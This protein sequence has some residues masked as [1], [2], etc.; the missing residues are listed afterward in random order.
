MLSAAITVILALLYYLWREGYIPRDPTGNGIVVG[1]AKAFDNRALSLR[2]ERL[3]A[4]LEALKVVNQSVTD[5][6][7]N[8]QGQTSTESAQA[9]SVAAKIA[10]AGGDGDGDGKNK[11]DADNRS[12]GGFDATRPEFKPTFGLA[13][14]DVLNNQLNL[15]SQIVNLQ[16]LYERSLSDRMIGNQSKLQT[17]LG[18]QISITPPAGYEDCVA[19]TEVA[20]RM[21]NKDGPV[22]LV[23]LMPQEKTYNAET[24]SS[25]ERSI[26]GS[27]V[28]PALTIG[29][30]GKGKA[31]QLFVHRDS[32]TIAFERSPQVTPTLFPDNGDHIV[33]GWEFR[34]VLGRRTVSPG[35]RQ[36]LAVV[37]LPKPDHEPPEK[38]ALEIRTRSYWRYYDRK[39]QVSAPHAGWL[40]W[41]IDGAGTFTSE[42]QELDI[43]NTAQIQT[44]L[45]PAITDI[46]WV[47]SGGD[48]ATVIVTGCNLF[49]GTKVLIGGEVH[50]EEEHNLTLKSDQAL[51]FGAPISSLT[52]A[53]AVLSGR[54]GPAIKLVIPPE[55]L[56]VATF[57][58]SRATVVPSRRLRAFY[59]SVD[60]KG[61]NV[62]AEYTDFTVDDIG[63]LPEPI[64]YLG[65]E[66]L[67]MPYDYYD[68]TAPMALDSAQGAASPGTVQGDDVAKDAPASNL[69][70]IV[71]VEVW[72][73]A[74]VLARN[75]S[76]SFR[77]PFCG[78]EYQASMP[79]SFTEPTIDRLGASGNDSVFRIGYPLG[80]ERAISV[81]LDVTYVEGSPQLQRITNSA[82][83][84]AQNTELILK[85]PTATI[86]KFQYILMRQAS[87]DPTAGSS[88]TFLLKIPQEEKLQPRVAVDTNSKPPKVAKGTRG[89]IDWTGSG[90]DQVADVSFTSP[91]PPGQITVAVSQ[92]FMAYEN[93]TKLQVYLTPQI[94]EIEGKFSLDCTTTSGEKFSLP[95]FVVSS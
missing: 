7:S 20:V 5:S 43:P 86:A 24:I 66:P 51:E 73:S 84:S 19:V 74:K 23:A 62:D 25:S 33:F 53:D 28:A 68:D 65:Q 82:F 6:L 31:Q 83:A 88:D 52:S 85:V 16:T 3:N 45:A 67:P 13:S 26:E 64:L 2:L 77:V 90:F 61:L 70:K 72:V 4:A 21:K 9:I 29:I 93:G 80:F 76:V 69:I 8:F 60:V 1:R 91:L 44:A 89:P 47:N 63:M 54:F 18:F 81:E 41:K 27:A 50:S 87:S 15:A 42:A 95:F 14:G 30:G 48:R 22:S 11:K 12:A 57:E 58:I 37:S 78:L 79:L 49:S 59:L 75:P 32:D 46:K 36:M 38:S 56:P 10:T 17:V 40:P 35:V 94:A 34:P 92:P 71:R 39:R 55:K